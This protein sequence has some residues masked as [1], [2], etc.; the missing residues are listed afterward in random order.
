MIKRLK[1][2][3]RWSKHSTDGT[4]YKLAVLIGIIH[5]PTL[6]FYSADDDREWAKLAEEIKR[7]AQSNR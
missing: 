6:Y 3:R 4:L 2:W 5:S 1:Q 7:N